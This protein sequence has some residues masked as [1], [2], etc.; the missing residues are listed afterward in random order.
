MADKSLGIRAVGD[1]ELSTVFGGSLWSGLKKVG[2]WIKNHVTATL[3]SIGIKG[4]F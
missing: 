2:R 1:E 4:T 3:H